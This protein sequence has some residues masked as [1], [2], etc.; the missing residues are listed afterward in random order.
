MRRGE[1]VEKSRNS[2]SYQK[3]L[4]EHKNLV[5]INC[6]FPGSTVAD[7]TPGSVACRT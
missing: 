4:V 7:A 5:C 3:F 2:R 6:A 1:Q